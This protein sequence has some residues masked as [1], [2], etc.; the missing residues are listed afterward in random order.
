MWGRKS[1]GEEPGGKT[2]SRAWEPKSNSAG[3]DW[4]TQSNLFRENKIN[5]ERGFIKLNENMRNIQY[6]I[7][8]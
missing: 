6:Y 3:T 4:R 5:D 1:S 8:I 2:L 7:R